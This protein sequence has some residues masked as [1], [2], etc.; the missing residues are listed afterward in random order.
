MIPY[1]ISFHKSYLITFKVVLY[2]FISE[3]N[4]NMYIHI[5]INLN[6]TYHIYLLEN[7]IRSIGTMLNNYEILSESN[8]VFTI[9]LWHKNYI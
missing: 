8:Q 3:K 7:D 2:L 4:I 1:R 5:I 9:N 6:L